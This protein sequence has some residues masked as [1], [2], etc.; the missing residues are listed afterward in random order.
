M[1]F[2]YVVVKQYYFSIASAI[3]HRLLGCTFKLC[4]KSFKLNYY[5][6]VLRPTGNKLSLKILLDYISSDYS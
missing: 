1:L 5:K 4:N 3:I 6:Y 2:M